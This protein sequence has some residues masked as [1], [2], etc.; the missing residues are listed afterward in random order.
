MSLRRNIL[1]NY[2]NQ[3]YVALIGI[4]MTPIYLRYMGAEAYGLVGFH[5]MLQAWFMLLDMGLTPTIA[6]ETARF[7]GGATEAVAYRQLV[8]ALEGLF[9]G[10]AVLGGGALF[11]AAGYLASGWLHAEALSP[12]EMVA[13]LRLVAAIVALRWMCGLYRGVITGSERLVWLGSYN[14]FIATLR[15]V[16]V[17]AV[18]EYGGVSPTSFFTYQL[19]VALVELL[20]LMFKAYPLL[21]ATQNP[22]GGSWSRSLKASLVKFSLT[23]GSVSAIWVVA[24]QTDKLLLS[25]LLPLAEYGY[26]TIAVMVASGIMVLSAPVSGAIMPRLTKLEAQG[27]HAEF[28]RIYRQATQLV[29]VITGALA[30]TL[31]FGAESLLWAWTGDQE[32]ARKAAPILVLYA[33]GNGVL[34]LSAFPYYMQ[35]AKGKLRLHLIGQ[36]GFIS[37]LIPLLVWAVGRFG[38]VGAGYAWLGINVIYFAG[39]VPLVHRNLAPGLNRTWY[40]HDSMVILLAVAATGYGLSGLLPESAGRVAQVAQL[41]GFG[42]VLL[43]TGA[44]CSSAARSAIRLR[45]K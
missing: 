6:R 9:F 34:A 20:G 32:L 35:F 11:A 41:F 10:V 23:V 27:D 21:P 8:K 3:L 43:L 39:W 33:L 13:A 5:T 26:F 17:L 42:V 31:A 12:D 15:Y 16:G 18:L 29:A 7:R 40:L 37:L 22:P 1:S 38:A 2:V 14:S 44:A 28:I 36:I 45:F 24:T 25:R 30:I 19:V 4:V